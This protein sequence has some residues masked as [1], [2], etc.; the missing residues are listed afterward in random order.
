MKTFREWKMNENFGETKEQTHRRWAAEA[1]TEDAINSAVEKIS[2]EYRK[3]IQ[4]VGDSLYKSLFPAYENW[5][6]Q[7]NMTGWSHSPEISAQAEQMIRVKIK[8]L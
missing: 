2:Y 8:G 7:K 1:G 6:T 4:K 5:M 3:K